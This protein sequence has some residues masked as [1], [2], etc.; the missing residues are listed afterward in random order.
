MEISFDRTEIEQSIVKRFERQVR[1]HPDRIAVKDAHQSISFTEFNRAANRIAACLLEKRG[2]TSEAVAILFDHGLAAMVAIL[3]VLKAGKYY[4]PLDPSY[5]RTTIEHMLKDSQ[6]AIILSDQATTDLAGTLTGDGITVI[7]TDRIENSTAN[8]NRDMTLSPDAYACLLYTS[9]STGLPKGIL[10]SHR[11]ILHHIWSHTHTFQ[12][13]STDCQA[14]LLSYSFAASIS[15]IFGALLNGATLSM[16]YVKKTGMDHLSKWL[17]SEKITTFKLP[18]SLFRL[19]L[20]T[21][22]EPSCFPDLRLIILGGDKLLRTDVELFRR[23]FSEDCLLVNRLASTEAFTIT[24]FFVDQTTILTE[25]VVPVGYPDHD[26][27][28]LILDEKGLP[29]QKGETGEMVIASRYLSPGYWNLPELNENKFRTLREKEGQRVFYTGDM[30]RIRPDGCLEHF[31]RKDDLIKIRGYRIELSSVEAALNELDEIREAIVTVHEAAKGIGGKK[32]AA[33]LVPADP[34]GLSVSQLRRKLAQ[35]LPG[36]MIP[37]NFVILDKFPLTSSGKIDRLTLPSPTKNRPA[38]DSSYVAPRTPTEESIME[39]WSEA[40]GLEQVGVTDNFFDLGGDSLMLFWVHAHIQDIFAIDIPMVILF[41]Y[42]T[43]MALAQFIIHRKGLPEG[44]QPVFG[45]PAVDAF[46]QESPVKKK[47][48]DD[49]DGQSF[50]EEIAIIGM[51]GT[52]PDAQNTEAFW[53]NIKNGVS[54]VRNYSMQELIDAGVDNDLLANPD[55]VKAG[56][57]L[58]DIEKFDAAF[59]G[60][61]S[62][63]AAILDPQHRLLLETAWHTLENAGYIPD[64]FKGRVGIYAGASPSAY[65]QK[66][67]M[68]Q[69]HLLPIVSDLRINLLNNPEFLTTRIAYT[70]NLKGPAINVTTACST[71]LVAVHLACRSLLNKECE[72]A[73]AGGVSVETPQKTG[74]L[75]QDGWMLSPDGQSRPFDAGARGIVISN[76]AGMVLLKRLREAVRDGDTIHAVIKGSAVNNDGSFKMGFTTPSVDG[77]TAVIEEALKNAG[78]NPETISYL[79]AHGTGT[80]LGDPIEITAL[81][82]AFRRYTWKTGFCAIGSVKSNIGHASRAAGI[83]GLLKTV[84]A[85]QHRQIPPSLNFAHP[86]PEIDFPASPFFVNTSLQDWPGEAGRPRRAGLSSFGVGGTNAHLI[87]EEWQETRIPPASKPWQLL[88]LSARTETAL[89]A[90]TQ[91]L[92]DYFLQNRDQELADVAYTLQAGRKAFACRRMLV[93]RDQEDAVALLASPSVPDDETRRCDFS[94]PNLVFMFPGEGGQSTDMA[95]DLYHQELLF[96]MNID[97]GAELFQPSLGIDLREILIPGERDPKKAAAAIAQKEIGRAAIFVV[98]YA[99]AR[100]LMSWGIY[101]EALI[102][103]GI[104]EYTAACL[105]G[106]MTLN[107][108]PAVFAHHH[109]ADAM[110]KIPLQQPVIPIVSG[111]TGTWLTPQEATDMAYWSRP[112]QEASHFSDG[113]NTLAISAHCVLLQAGPGGPLSAR[114]GGGQDGPKAVM[115]SVFPKADEKCSA[116]ETMLRAIG[117]MWLAGVQ[118]DWE[119]FHSQ[120]PGR[121]LPLPLY[122]F[123]KKRYWI[124]RASAGQ[125]PPTGTIRFTD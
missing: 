43:I 54:S 13:S 74:Y 21:L 84:L 85:L 7:N 118:I 89:K 75:Y 81:N 10:H 59:F 11:T 48:R 109:D 5:P 103:R 62:V 61:R 22:K 108:M 79:E 116:R 36:Y 58:K 34:A 70:L 31:G 72:L 67:I 121:R 69:R 15:E 44:P 107:E 98:E 105:S 46:R 2:E 111:I 41:K 50:P 68:P 4:V 56:T 123:E 29:V 114:D 38:L 77:Q 120:E 96:R 8:D 63:E 20:N 3:A 92:L 1:L 17:Q 9:G 42:P 95:A 37:A 93:C 90:A 97:H 117:K 40:L 76:G 18:V 16:N 25:Q 112:W 104:G 49:H 45:T 99:M 24:R 6:A 91:N 47:N 33:Y 119:N 64:D 122:P 26:K 100:L 55:Y 87:L 86:N 80:G 82:Q 101:P 73:L 78:V 32:L 110:K 115:L 23:F 125:I 28:I 35:K 102:G 30:G 51:A 94:K 52:F 65:L 39:I 60:L 12:I 124:P 27:E 83:A 53:E 57:F 113:L 14:L 106:V 66:H 19:F 88:V 71:S